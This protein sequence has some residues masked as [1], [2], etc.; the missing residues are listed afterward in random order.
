MYICTKTTSAS[1]AVSNSNPAMQ[2]LWEL[3]EHVRVC[4]HQ[5]QCIEEK[6]NKNKNKQRNNQKT[7]WLVIIGLIMRL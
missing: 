5:R 1:H 7:N 4:A 2:Q 3:D 6:T